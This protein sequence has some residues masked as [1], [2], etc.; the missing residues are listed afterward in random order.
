MTQGLEKQTQRYTRLLQYDISTPLS[1][2]YVSEYI[3]PLPAYVDPT[4]KASKNPKIA[5]QSEIHALGNGQFFVLSRD[6]GAGHGQDDSQSVYRQIDVFDVTNATDIKGDE[7]DCETCAVADEDSG[8]LVDGV[9]VATYCSFLDF[10]VNS[11]LGRFGLHNGGDQDAQL[12]VSRSVLSSLQR[13]GGRILVDI[14]NPLEREVG[15]DRHSAREPRRVRR[16][17]LRLQP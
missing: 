8:E 15:V 14:G 7:Y 10:N 2:V 16:R 9:A 12:L 3:V 17:V 6:S 1:P 5:A 11:Q 4:A 13:G